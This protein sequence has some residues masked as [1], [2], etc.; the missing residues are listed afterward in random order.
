MSEVQNGLSHLA[1]QAQMLVKEAQFVV[2]KF[3]EFQYYI[4]LLN[5]V[6]NDEIERKRHQRGSKTVATPT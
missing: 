3:T 2:T 5:V 4:S 6:I 1:W